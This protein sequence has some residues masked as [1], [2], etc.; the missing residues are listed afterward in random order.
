[1]AAL[2]PMRVMPAALSLISLTVAS[3]PLTKIYA[4]TY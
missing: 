1:M 3:L 4:L 2:W